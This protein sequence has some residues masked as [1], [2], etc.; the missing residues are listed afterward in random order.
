VR[1]AA[2]SRPWVP[3]HA[4]YEYLARRCRANHG[5]LPAPQTGGADGPILP[6]VDLRTQLTTVAGLPTVTVE[7]VVD[8]ASIA[9]L[10]DALLRAVHANPAATVLV[11]VDAVTAIDDAGLGILL[12][13]AAAARQAEGDLEIVCSS[14]RLR[15]RLERTRLDRAITVRDSIR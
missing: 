14:D 2:S 13:A 3:R 1:A 12:G 8:L 10:R 4:A 11:D 7:G 15:L 9:P 5:A 6:D